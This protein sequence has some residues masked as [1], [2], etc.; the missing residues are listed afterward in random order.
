MENNMDTKKSKKLESAIKSAPNLITSLF[1]CQELN[2]GSRKSIMESMCV[3][4]KKRLF[5]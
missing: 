5:E 4:S 1:S 3:W 2:S